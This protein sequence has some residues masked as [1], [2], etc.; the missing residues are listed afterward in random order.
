[1]LSGAKLGMVSFST[2]SAGQ[3]AKAEASAAVSLIEILDIASPLLPS[4]A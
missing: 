2:A 3:T 1:V 4:A